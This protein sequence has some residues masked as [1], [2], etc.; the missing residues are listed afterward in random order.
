MKTFITRWI[1]RKY[2][3]IMFDWIEIN[4]AW[5]FK[6]NPTNLAKAND[7]LVMAME[8]IDQNTIDNMADREFEEK[9]KK[10]L[11]MMNYDNSPSIK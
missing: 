3:E 10:Y 11:D 5:D 6:L 4:N 2:N 7:Y 8:E 9:S 1:K